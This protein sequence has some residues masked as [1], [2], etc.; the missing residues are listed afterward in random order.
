MTGSVTVPGPN[1]SIVASDSSQATSQ[2]SQFLISQI[3]ANIYTGI[4]NNTLIPQDIG[5]GGNAVVY[6]GGTLSPTVPGATVPSGSSGE[7]V[8]Y[9]QGEWYTASAGQTILVANPNS[10]TGVSFASGV[11]GLSATVSGGP[12]PSDTTPG[13]HGDVLVLS[14]LSTN[15]P[16]YGTVVFRGGMNARIA[17]EAPRS[18]S[19]DPERPTH[20]EPSPGLPGGIRGDIHAVTLFGGYAIVT[21]SGNDSIAALGTINGSIFP[22]AG[23]NLVQLGD[24]AYFVESSGTDTVIAGAGT[25]VVSVAGA[26]SDFVDG[27]NSALWFING[28]AVSTVFGGLG[29]SATID[30]GSGGGVFFGGFAGH[31]SINAGT[32][33]ASLF[34]AGDGDVLRAGGAMPQALYAGATGQET[35]DAGAAMGPVTI[36]GSGA[37]TDIRLGAG[38]DVV[39]LVNGLGGGSNT[40]TGF[41]PA[42]DVIALSGYS[43]N[44]I[45][46]AVANETIVDGSLNV[47]LSDGS[48]LIFAG[49]TSL[50]TTSQVETFTFSI[51][52]FAA[53]THIRTAS[54]ETPVEQLCVG[55]HVH[56]LLGSPTRPIA[57]IG[58][59]RVNCRRHPKP[60]QVWPVRVSA[61][62]LGP[63]LPSR[64]L[65][66]SPD[67]AVFLQDVLIPVKHLINGTSIVQVP[68]DEVTYHHI[69]LTRHDVVFAEGQPAESYLDVGD[70][71]K[72]DNGGKVM[73][74]HPDF[75]T[76]RNDASLVWEARGCAPLVVCGPQFDAARRSVRP[77]IS[78]SAA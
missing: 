1:G 17:V 27:A 16:G 53:G 72:F 22:G 31:N 6:N 12:Q 36:Y 40:I 70:R 47:V 77:L 59:R 63:A 4:A 60:T 37:N 26:N 32:G 46:N 49:Y 50:I 8:I 62:A 56:T 58:Q 42:H 15:I 29:G 18:P 33:A 73:A 55:D 65:H 30:G 38:L 13:F 48:K 75:S 64:D 35:L 45:P 5:S 51:V 61:G 67:H 69:E 78:A 19:S 71:G 54:G 28:S 34:A 43:D 10:P 21:D 24:G 9:N 23:N 11:I 66:L 44:E 7:M 68:V 52:C 2:V 74:L 3:V 76:H 14:G 41:N 20:W 39:A 25:E 57:W